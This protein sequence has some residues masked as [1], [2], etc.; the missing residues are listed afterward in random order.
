[1]VVTSHPK[2]KL[3]VD[4]IQVAAISVAVATLAAVVLSW[5][6]P[7]RYSGIVTSLA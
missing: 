7:K 4:A 3:V 2:P 1:M 6:I 5:A